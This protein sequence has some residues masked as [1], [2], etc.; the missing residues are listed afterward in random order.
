MLVL[1]DDVRVCADFLEAVDAMVAARPNAALSLHGRH[2][3]FAKAQQL[4]LHWVAS[5][6]SFTGIAHVLPS[7]WVRG[8]LDWTAREA[9]RWNPREQSDARVRDYVLERGARLCVPVP[10]PV[11]HRPDMKSLIPE[12]RDNAYWCST[13]Y[14]GDGARLADEPWTELDAL[15][16]CGRLEAQCTC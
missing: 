2:G 16:E 7:A 8:L 1:Q 11:D 12:H 6:R 14:A 3:P 5:R 4:G 10:H 9:H 13:V 15:C